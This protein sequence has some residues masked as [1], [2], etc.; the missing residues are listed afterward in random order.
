MTICLF[1]DIGRHCCFVVLFMRSTV[2]D[3]V[4]RLTLSTVC[5][6]E[7]ATELHKQ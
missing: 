3:V 2:E 7:Q 6:M 4:K 5:P 1:P